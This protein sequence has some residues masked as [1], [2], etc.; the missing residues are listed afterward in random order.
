MK[1]QCLKPHQWARVPNQSLQ[2]HALKLSDVRGW[3][4]LC[5][6]PISML[7]LHIPEED[8][9]IDVLEL[10]EMDRLLRFVFLLTEQ[11]LE[12][13]KALIFLFFCF[14]VSMLTL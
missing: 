13:F 3:S 10:I 14:P 5:E 11:T 9:C 7:A 6:D 12:N 8:R 1:V 2:V 4:M